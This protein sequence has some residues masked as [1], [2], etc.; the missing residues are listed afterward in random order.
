MRS[1]VFSIFLTLA[2]MPSQSE[3]QFFVVDEMANRSATALQETELW[4]WAASIEMIFRVAGV[5]WS[6]TD[7]V[8]AVKGFPKLETGS[9]QEMTLFLNGWGFSYNGQSWRGE[10]KYYSG[11]M[12]ATI[13]IDEINSG[14]PVIMAL[15]TGGMIEHAVVVY[16]V[17]A[18]PGKP[19]HSIYY[20]DP[21]TGAKDAIPGSAVKSIVTHSWTAKIFVGS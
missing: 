15:R 4:C 8:N 3:A 11:A 16:G 14:R 20:F 13:L 6:Q 9:P 1:I 7:I 19:V 21:Y 2:S 5:P 17:L 18:P 12:P 10:S